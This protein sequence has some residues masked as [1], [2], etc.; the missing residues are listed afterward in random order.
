LGRKH[1]RVPNEKSSRK[2]RCRSD[3]P[4]KARARLRQRHKPPAK[5][6]KEG[7]AGEA[8]TIAEMKPTIIA[9]LIH[10]KEA[11]NSSKHSSPRPLKRRKNKPR[12]HH[13]QESLPQAAAP[14]RHTGRVQILDKGMGTEE[15]L[16]VKKTVSSAAVVRILR[17]GDIDV[18]V[19]DEASNSKDTRRVPIVARGAASNKR[20]SQL[21]T[22]VLL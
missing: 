22:N 8:L 21:S 3:N 1:D 14:T 12:K 5:A 16:E 9:D 4:G 17:S 7:I 19:P 15:V 20:R 13:G 18:T 6:S 10:I 11:S 2:E